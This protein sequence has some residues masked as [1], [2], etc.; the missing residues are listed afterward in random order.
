MGMFSAN[1]TLTFGQPINMLQNNILGGPFSTGNNQSLNLGYNIAL[2][3]GPG[4][5]QILPPGFGSNVQGP[6]AYGSPMGSLANAPQPPMAYYP[7]QQPVQQP[8]QPS[9]YP[10]Q[11]PQPVPQPAPQPQPVCMPCGYPP[12]AVKPYPPP[13][14]LYPPPQQPPIIY[15]P[16]YVVNAAQ[17]NSLQIDSQIFHMLFA[18][19]AKAMAFKKGK[20]SPASPCKTSQKPVRSKLLKKPQKT[21]SSFTQ[22]LF[23]MLLLKT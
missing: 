11:Q 16:V 15:Q 3:N 4:A 14:P 18:S 2:N 12:P 17:Q 5:Q 13:R 8:Q 9:Y 19:F 22:L 6:L 7:P 10:M 20:C 1:N 21:S 23:T